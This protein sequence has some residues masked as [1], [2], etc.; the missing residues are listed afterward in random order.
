MLKCRSSARSYIFPDA[1]DGADTD[2]TLE[3]TTNSSN[4]DFGRFTLSLNGGTD[5]GSAIEFDLASGANVFTFTTPGG[6]FGNYGGL[7]LFFAPTTGPGSG[8]LNPSDTGYPADLALTIPF[9]GTAGNP[10]APAAGTVIQDYGVGDSTT[11][12]SGATSY[13][14]GGQI[15]TLS[16]A[17]A[18]DSSSGGFTINVAAAPEPS[19]WVL[20]IASL[21]GFCTLS[22]YFRKIA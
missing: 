1:A 2:V 6:T 5:Q 4:S 13:T 22:R 17:S 18:T 15:I 11:K 14:V 10:T 8:S 21:V 7:E 12:Y 19:T 20:M 3:Y 16:D 9:K